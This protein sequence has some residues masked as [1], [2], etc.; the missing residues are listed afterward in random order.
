M[1]FPVKLERELPADVMATLRREELKREWRECREAVAAAEEQLSKAHGY[2]MRDY[3]S[4][5]LAARQQEMRAV[6]DEFVRA[7]RENRNVF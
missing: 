1:I 2:G 4:G 5:K 6:G 7:C 3:W